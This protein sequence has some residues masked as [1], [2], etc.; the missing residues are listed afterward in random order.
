[1]S[2]GSKVHRVSDRNLFKG[3][4]TAM[5]WQGKIDGK[6]YKYRR[7]KAEDWRPKGL[8]ELKNRAK[9]LPRDKPN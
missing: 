7:E 1:M 5:P 8:I 4:T 2:F 3:D 6:R 9:N